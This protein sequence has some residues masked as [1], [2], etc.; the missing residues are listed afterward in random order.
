MPPNKNKRILFPIWKNDLFLTDIKSFDCD[1][2]LFAPM[3]HSVIPYIKEI[4]REFILPDSYLS[5]IDFHAVNIGVEKIF[6]TLFKEFGDNSLYLYISFF[7]RYALRSVLFAEI[8]AK[9]L[10]RSKNFNKINLILNTNSQNKIYLNIRRPLL[11]IKNAFLDIIP[12]SDL[13]IITSDILLS[14]IFPHNEYRQDNSRYDYEIIKNKTL[15]ICYKIDLPRIAGI[16]SHFKNSNEEFAI[17]IITSTNSRVI[18]QNFLDKFGENLLISKKND[19][20]LL[21]SKEIYQLDYIHK[22][23][24]HLPLT[25]EAL[26]KSIELEFLSCKACYN[27]LMDIFSNYRPSRVF[28]SYGPAHKHRISEK[29][30]IDSGIDL[31]SFSHAEFNLCDFL[32]R[33]KRTK[34]YV[35]SSLLKN[36]FN[37]LGYLNVDIANFSKDLVH[38]IQKPYRIN[39]TLPIILIFLGSSTLSPPSLNYR[40]GP[41]RFL[42]S[43]QEIVTPP[44][45]LNDKIR[46]LCKS[47]PLETEIEYYKILNIDS[48]IFLPNDADVFSLI[49]QSTVVIGFNYASSPIF[50]GIKKR[51]PC[52]LFYDKIFADIASFE[53]PAL[54]YMQNYISCFTNATQYWSFI[55]KLIVDQNELNKLIQTQEPI[56]LQLL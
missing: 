43:L 12:K 54:K 24:G 27:F 38:Y 36:A 29:A 40:S 10:Y 25:A 32:P 21:S 48:S 55:E 30:T 51:K 18:P 35:G 47:H 19:N 6:K 45:H 9:K 28:V 15:I 13:N 5:E 1:K 2:I 37:S 11:A 14:S 50:D 53:Y 4:N 7:L 34:F 17:L 49:N 56:R 8:L 39:T 26:H 42:R 41:T 33:H 52:I 44:S 3:Q 31:Y 46:I 20:I 16:I 22:L 23:F